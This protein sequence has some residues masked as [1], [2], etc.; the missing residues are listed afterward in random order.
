MGCYA[1]GG[2]EGEGRGAGNRKS[3][4]RNP[5][6]ERKGEIGI[7]KFENGNRG[8][9]TRTRTR[10]KKEILTEGRE[11][12]EG[13]ERGSGRDKLCA[14][15]FFCRDLVLDFDFDGGK[16]ALQFFN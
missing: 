11:G 6:T 5:K 1:G 3:E 10:T 12:N 8:R 14:Q 16:L 15:Y 4:I 9:R 13:E 2:N 7:S